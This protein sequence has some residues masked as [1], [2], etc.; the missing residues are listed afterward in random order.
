MMV[1]TTIE[2][3]SV[4]MQ[5]EGS[6]IRERDVYMNEEGRRESNFHVSLRLWGFEF[7]RWTW[8]QFVD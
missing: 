4:R 3:I 2:G 1:N 6:K 8:E 5:E 7:K